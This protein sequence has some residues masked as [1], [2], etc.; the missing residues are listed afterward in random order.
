MILQIFIFLM[1]ENIQF[2]SLNAEALR[3]LIDFAYTGMYDYISYNNITYLLIA[4]F[5][6]LIAYLLFC[7][8]LTFISMCINV[9][10]LSSPV[11]K[12]TFCTSVS[13]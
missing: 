10:L 12:H 6:L 3:A 9:L 1:Q 7:I 8:L 2:P 11:L 13:D 5:Y 4:F